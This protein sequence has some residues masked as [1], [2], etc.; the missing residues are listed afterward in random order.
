ME[1]HR[2]SY[3]FENQVWEKYVGELIGI[4][5]RLSLIW[6]AKLKK[7]LDISKYFDQNFSKKTL[8]ILGV[9]NRHSSQ[10]S[11]IHNVCKTHIKRYKMYIK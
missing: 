4:H 2:V 8:Q 1:G 5:I 3:V 10:K 6:T 7:N 11:N 9:Q